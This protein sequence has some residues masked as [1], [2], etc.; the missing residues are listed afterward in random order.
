MKIQAAKKQKKLAKKLRKLLDMTPRRNRLML[1][2]L[3]KYLKVTEIYTCAN[4]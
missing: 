1:T 4:K 2:K 3:R